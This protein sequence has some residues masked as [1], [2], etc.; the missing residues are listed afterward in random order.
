M[1]EEPSLEK[2]SGDAG[3]ESAPDTIKDS[4]LQR[5][6]GFWK[7]WWRRTVCF[8]E[9][10]KPGPRAWRG[11]GVG[12]LIAVGLVYLIVGLWLIVLA[13]ENLAAYIIT[14]ALPPLVLLA[15][16]LGLL[17]LR[18]VNRLPSFYLWVLISSAI[19]ITLL[20][21][22]FSALGIVTCLVVCVLI[23]SLTGAAIRILAGRGWRGLTRIQ[24]VVTALG[25][26]GGLAL[27]GFV[28]WWLLQ[29]GRPDKETPNAALDT[30]GPAHSAAQAMED[31]SKPGRYRVLRLTYGSGSDRHRPEYAAQVK[32]RTRTVDGSRLIERWSGRQGW[33]RTRYWGFDAKKLPLQA[34]VWYPEGDGPFPLVLIV[35][36]NHM[37][38]QYSDPGYAY[39]GELMASRGFV[40]AS[41][42]ENFLN[43]SPG[44][45]TGVPDV[46]LKEENDARGWLLLEHLRLW[47]EWNKTPGSV[48][49]GRIDMDR[50]AV[51]GHSRGGE[52]A[53]V[54][55][56]FN[57]L[58]YYPDDARVRFDF[59]FN[60]RSVLAIA[61][62]DGQYKPAGEPTRLENLN[63]FVLHG[64]WDGDMKSFHGA[65]VL[66]RTRF[67]GDGDWFKAT[68][69][70]HH[71]NHGQ[72]NTVWG[73]SDTGGPYTAFLNLRPMLPAG[74]QQQIARVFIS[75]FLEATLHDRREY[76][77]LLRDWRAG[78]SWLPKT[79]YL[80]KYEEARSKMLA[81]YEEDIDLTTTTAPGGKIRGENLSDWKERAV[82][83]KWG[84]LD[85]RGVFLGWNRKE[86]PGPS[87]YLL[88]LPPAGLGTAGDSALF[89]SLADSKSKP[90][91]YKDE[92]AEGKGKKTDNAK[93][94]TSGKDDSEDKAEPIDLTLELA[95]GAGNTARLP[96][97]YYAKLQPQIETQVTKAAFMND[98]GPSEVV[99][100]TFEFPLAAFVSVNPKLD[101]TTLRSL[102]LVFDRS[103]KGVVILDDVGFRGGK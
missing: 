85:T 41:V 90:S 70:I 76:R 75:A 17:L 33:A 25:L 84:G 102:R 96:L 14:L 100:Q 88:E 101:A 69:Y 68:L 57:R 99:F 86:A 34:R 59:G 20:S 64:S 55:G 80:Q 72:F 47:R 97:S 6:G 91:S 62:V 37:M 32:I 89:F 29:D 18:L 52:A 51:A 30:V 22:G 44:D 71:A 45:L 2:E 82:S 50:I 94:K 49:Y 81:T 74:D 12:M 16:G 21:A 43:S 8:L 83:I 46:G 36:G 79:I 40:F 19:L 28:A 42:D 9:R 35:H 7:R 38:E 4:N 61:P 5:R 24:R 92:E 13:R 54:A 53:A 1:S 65:R 11:A 98:A 3:A 77:Q 66:E 15:G 56:V 48:F 10:L 103:E 78:A 58:P 39:L 93:N 87:S 95:D 73:R 27:A 67:T 26:V 31:P 60:I 63:Y 23:G